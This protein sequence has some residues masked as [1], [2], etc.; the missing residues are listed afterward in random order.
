VIYI[1]N[2]P[3]A[4]P[5][6][7]TRSDDDAARNW[8]KWWRPRVQADRKAKSSETPAASTD[9]RAS[10]KPAVAPQRTEAKNP[11]QDA[12]EEQHQPFKPAAASAT[13]TPPTL[14][15]PM[16]AAPA[17]SARAS[18][19]TPISVPRA[20]A[21]DA[22]APATDNVVRRADSAHDDDDEEPDRDGGHHAMSKKDRKKLRKIQQREQR[23]DFD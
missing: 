10:A 5:A 21:A 8:L 17:M 6:A 12:D 11:P 4:L 20:A 13:R 16:P 22:A 1:T 19:N 2:E 9:R 3:C 15:A 14:A 23:S 7:T 18:V